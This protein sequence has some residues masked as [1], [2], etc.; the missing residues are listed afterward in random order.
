MALVLKQWPVCHSMVA[1]FAVGG[2]G[3]VGW[4][5]RPFAVWLWPWGN[6]GALAVGAWRLAAVA[7]RRPDVVGS[8]LFG[9]LPE[10]G[11]GMGARPVR[12]L[13]YVNPDV[14]NFS[15]NVK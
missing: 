12:S 9:P 14:N 10:A 13:I 7:R 8:R 11:R 2:G 4:R 15:S 5:G 6:A 3:G 1:Y